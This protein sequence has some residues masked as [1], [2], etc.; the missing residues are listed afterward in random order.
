[1]LFVSGARGK[2]VEEGTP[3]T[4]NIKNAPIRFEKIYKQA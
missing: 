1:M 4:D 2:V 3:V